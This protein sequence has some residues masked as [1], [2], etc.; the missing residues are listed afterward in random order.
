MFSVTHF[1]LK[2]QKLVKGIFKMSDNFLFWAMPSTNLCIK[3]EQNLLKNVI[4]GGNTWIQICIYT[5]TC[6]LTPKLY[7]SGSGSVLISN[8]RAWELLCCNSSFFL[9]KFAK[10]S[11]QLV[12]PITHWFTYLR[13]WDLVCIAVRWLQKCESQG[14]SDVP[15]WTEEPAWEI[16]CPQ[17]LSPPLPHSIRS[18]SL[19]CA[20]ETGAMVE[21]DSPVSD[22]QD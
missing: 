2:R 8:S 22:K 14:L 12:L 1:S 7:F 9:R 10:N 19:L 4:Y 16:P 5:K 6:E 11:N 18:S 3:Y 21:L 17:A 20:D 13:F 15:R